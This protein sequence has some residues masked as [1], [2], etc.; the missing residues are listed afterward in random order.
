MMYCF[1]K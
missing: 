1:G